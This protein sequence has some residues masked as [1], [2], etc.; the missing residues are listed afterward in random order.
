MHHQSHKE[1]V[2][3]FNSLSVVLTIIRRKSQFGGKYVFCFLNKESRLLYL[4][5]M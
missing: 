5:K 4:T 2:F 3:P 1:K